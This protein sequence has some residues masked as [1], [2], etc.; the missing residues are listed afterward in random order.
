[1][2]RTLFIAAL[3]ASSAALSPTP[4]DEKLYTIELAPGETRI[5]TDAEKLALRQVSMDTKPAHISTRLRL[6]HMP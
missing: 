3:A 2:F 1:M 5:V 6:S 4:R